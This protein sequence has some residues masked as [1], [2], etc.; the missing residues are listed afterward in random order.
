MKTASEV[1][2]NLQSRVAR[3]ED[4]VIETPDME[5]SPFIENEL[6]DEF[7]SLDLEMQAVKSCKKGGF[8]YLVFDHET[9]KSAIISEMSGVQ[10]ILSIENSWVEGQ[11]L[12]NRLTTGNNLL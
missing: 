8:C 9:N 12:F 4:Q 6:A 3:L 5:L 2:R 1:I 7:D 10:K 11:S